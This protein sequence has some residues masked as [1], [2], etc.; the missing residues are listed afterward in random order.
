[1][2]DEMSGD[3]ALCASLREVGRA[4]G[5]SAVRRLSG[6][7]IADA[8][9]ISWADGTS[10]VGKIVNGAAPDLFRTEADGLAALR[11]TGHLATPDVLAVTDQLL[12]L[13]ALVPRDDSADS[14]EAFGRDMAGAH[15]AVVSDRFGWAADGWLGRLRQVNTW[16]ADGHEF[17]AEHRLL[18]YLTEPPAEQAL[19][20]DDRRA[21]ERLCA[22]L[23][24]LIP[25]M[26]AVLTPRRPVDRQFDQPAGR[27][28]HRH[29]PGRLLHL[30]R[31]RPVHAVGQPT[32]ARF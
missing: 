3:D 17:F 4:D 18:R 29:R 2:P 30:G 20:A 7:V 6:G 8:W 11:G 27:P 31:G 16:N 13:E 28:D 23:P 5:I 14:W 32:P 21:V 19:T 25:P 26:P 12:L 22:R 9:L 1:M 15:R 10:A 24:E